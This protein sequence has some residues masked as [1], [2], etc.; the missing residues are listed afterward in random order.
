MTAAPPEASEA[1]LVWEDRGDGVVLLRLNR[2]KRLNAL[3][4]ELVGEL[5]RTCAALAAD[6][7]ARVVV[8]T[9]TL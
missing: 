7:E 4:E 8:L 5:L 2:P 6:R 9:G 1:S 3:D